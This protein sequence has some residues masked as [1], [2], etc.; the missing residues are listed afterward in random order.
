MVF[1]TKAGQKPRH[2]KVL[3]HAKKPLALLDVHRLIAGHHFG[4]WNSFWKRAKHHLFVIIT[5]LELCVCVCVHLPNPEAQGNLGPGHFPLRQKTRSQLHSS[6]DHGLAEREVPESVTWNEWRGVTEIAMKERSKWHEFPGFELIPL[7]GFWC[8]TT[9]DCCSLWHGF[10]QPFNQLNNKTDYRK[11]D[12]VN[13][14]VSLVCHVRSSLPFRT[15]SM[16]LNFSRM[17]SF[18]RGLRCR[19]RCLSQNCRDLES[20]VG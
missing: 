12:Y 7:K 8:M 18:S 3:C 16:R 1:S 17:V 4:D 13:P 6:L 10:D 2:M 11:V 19:T 5:W 15:L 20:S 14:R 9:V